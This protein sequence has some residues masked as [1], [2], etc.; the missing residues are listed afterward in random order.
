MVQFCG[1]TRDYVHNEKRIRIPKAPPWVRK[2]TTTTTTNLV[3]ESSQRNLKEI[4]VSFTEER[5]IELNMGYDHQQDV[6]HV[7]PRN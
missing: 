6:L 2:S 3:E 7:Q 4:C 5:E 1:F